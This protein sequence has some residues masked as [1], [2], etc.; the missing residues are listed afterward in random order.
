MLVLRNAAGAELNRLSYSVAGQANVSRSLRT[1]LRITN[2]TAVHRKSS[3]SIRS[4]T[5]ESTLE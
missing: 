3:T 5:E 4:S 1:G 2:L